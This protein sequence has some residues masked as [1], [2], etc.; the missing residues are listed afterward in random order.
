M[1]AALA[2]VT[3]LGRLPFA[4]TSTRIAFNDGAWV[5]VRGTNVPPGVNGNTTVRTLDASGDDRLWPVVGLA[6]VPGPRARC[7]TSF[8]GDKPFT[9]ARQGERHP[10]ST[11]AM[12][13]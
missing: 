7:R 9:V 11:A 8:E 1:V 6:Q 13:N 4:A 10:A 2:F 5:A 12:L 3:D